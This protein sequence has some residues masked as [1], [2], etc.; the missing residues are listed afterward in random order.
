MLGEATA[1]DLAAAIP[2]ILNAGPPAPPDVMSVGSLL[3][4]VRAAYHAYEATHGRLARPFGA[5]CHQGSH[6]R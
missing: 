1:E 4:E 6:A 5:R 2:A 3:D